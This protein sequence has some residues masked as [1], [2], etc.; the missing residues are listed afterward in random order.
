MARHAIGAVYQMTSDNCANRDVDQCNQRERVEGRREQGVMG[1]P[2][3][4]TP[5]ITHDP[6]FGVGHN[7]LQHKFVIV[8]KLSTH[9]AIVIVEPNWLSNLT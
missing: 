8:S 7:S 9:R 1:A 3:H 5:G 6:K 2:H 4:C